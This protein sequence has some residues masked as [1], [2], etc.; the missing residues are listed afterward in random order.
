M[1][2]H[3]PLAAPPPDIEGLLSR[4]R[5]IRRWR[6]GSDAFFWRAETDGLLLPVR[7]RRSVAYRWEAVFRFEGGLPPVGCE[8][9]YREDLLL[10]EQVATLAC[11]GRDWVLHRAKTGD[12]PSRQVGLQ[13]RFVPAEVHRWLESWT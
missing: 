4:R 6:H 10:P 12:L 7:R 11:R 8:Q 2:R 3:T 9:A 5:L 13:V 1:G